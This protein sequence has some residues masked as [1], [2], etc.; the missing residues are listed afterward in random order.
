[1]VLLSNVRSMSHLDT[2]KLEEKPYWTT[3]MKDM[4]QISGNIK[5]M[6]KIHQTD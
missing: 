6:I 1:M 5:I 3:Y 2:V 4:T